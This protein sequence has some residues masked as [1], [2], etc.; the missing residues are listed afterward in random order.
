MRKLIKNSSKILIC[1][2]HFREKFQK[3]GNS[4]RENFRYLDQS[5]A[6][7]GKY[8]L[9]FRRSGGKCNFF[10]FL[11]HKFSMNPRGTKN[12]NFFDAIL[13]VF[14]DIKELLSWLKIISF[15]ILQTRISTI[16]KM[17]KKVITTLFFV[18]LLGA[19]SA[20]PQDDYEDEMMMRR[21]FAK[22]GMRKNNEYNWGASMRGPGNAFWWGWVAPRGASRSNFIRSKIWPQKNLKKTFSFFMIKTWPFLV[23]KL[24]AVEKIMLFFMFMC[25]F[26]S[27]HK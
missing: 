22:R 6:F 26:Y 20:A 5:A 9:D 11:P 15:D 18:T 4:R 17:L 10:N 8:F 14:R 19:A 16:T 3:N 23:K 7:I 12:I 21:A 25:I 13:R 1:S 2:W 24:I 27:F